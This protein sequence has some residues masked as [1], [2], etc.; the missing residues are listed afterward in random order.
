MAE[1]RG[2]RVSFFSPAKRQL[3]QPRAADD[4]D[5]GQQ[6]FDDRPHGGGAEHQRLLAAAPVQ[7]AVG[8]DVAAL[9]IGG[10]L[11]FVDGK[12]R[13]V[14]IATASPRRWQTQKRGLGGLIF[15]SPVTSATASAPTRSTAR[16]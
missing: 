9:E 2:S 16:L 8:E 5:A 6:P 4:A 13:D 11:D 12:E 7:H 14:E 10:E 15:S 3:R 1:R